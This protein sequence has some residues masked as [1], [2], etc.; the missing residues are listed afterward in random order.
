[1]SHTPDIYWGLFEKKNTA[2]KVTM[3]GRLLAV[4][5]ETMDVL[6]PVRK[7]VL[8]EF[9]ILKIDENKSYP[10]EIRNAIHKAVLDKYGPVALI[11]IVTNLEN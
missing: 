3:H 4:I 2:K 10:I 8:K 5:I 1:M 7:E 6:G 11:N 9:G